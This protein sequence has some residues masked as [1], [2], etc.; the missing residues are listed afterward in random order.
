MYMKVGNHLGIM[1]FK[2]INISI[3]ERPSSAFNT[4]IQLRLTMMRSI[5]AKSFA[6]IES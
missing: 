4:S 1:C 2:H 6:N 5:N 3:N